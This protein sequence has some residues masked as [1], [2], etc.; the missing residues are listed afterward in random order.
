[1]F[2]K[3]VERVRKIWV[4]LTPRKQSHPKIP[5]FFF[6]F[7]ISWFFHAW[8]FFHVFQSLGEPYQ[9]CPIINFIISI[10]LVSIWHFSSLGFVSRQCGILTM[11]DTPI[12]ARFWPF[13]FFI[14]KCPYI[15]TFLHFW[16]LVIFWKCGNVSSDFIWSILQPN[17]SLFPNQKW[18]IFSQF[19]SFFTISEG[20]HCIM[21]KNF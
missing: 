6:N 3:T 21:L 10:L 8:N 5:W 16:I 15:D 14:W 7:Q 20:N 11:I 1:M 4:L 12:L 9:H 17:F 13:I 18:P 2:L 19:W